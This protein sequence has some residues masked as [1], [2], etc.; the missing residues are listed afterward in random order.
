MSTAAAGDY[1]TKRMRLTVL[2]MESRP[3]TPPPPQESLVSEPEPVALS[4]AD[5]PDEPPPK[6]EQECIVDPRGDLW[7]LAQGT[8]SS[9]CSDQVRF[10]VCSRTLA[11]ASPVFDKMLFG[12]FAE[13]SQ[14]QSG[15]TWEVELP[16]D[17]SSVTRV[18]FEIMHSRYQ[19]L[20]T[21]GCEDP[22]V[23]PLLYD[24]T[25]MADKYDC[26]A[27]FRP[28]ASMWASHLDIDAHGKTELSLLRMS[29]I[30]HQLG[31]IAK[32]EAVL[33][34]LIMDYPLD[35]N[36]SEDGQRPV[37][38]VLPPDVLEDVH[39]LRLQMLRELL[40]PIARTIDKLMTS[41]DSPAGVCIF[42][43]ISRYGFSS[44][45]DELVCEALMLGLALRKLK[46]QNLWPLPEPE[47]MSIGPRALDEVITN[48][49]VACKNPTVH[50]AC[51]P[52]S[53][54]RRNRS[55]NPQ[56]TGLRWLYY[57][58]YKYE[59]GKE[60]GHFEARAFL[61]GVHEFAPDKLHKSRDILFFG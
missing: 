19:R 22:T 50:P 45:G 47:N 18:L 39:R 54:P 61:L 49:A 53:A 12:R 5:T 43:L 25:I 37:P 21:M 57:T 40:D 58:N 10:R 44:Q 42:G 2:T 16:E 33:T 24:L 15:D 4:D 13:S 35:R 23:V 9:G 59:A 29:W 56:F 46:S 38:Q 60:R 7:L 6:P 52:I 34:T 17:P 30:F 26:V 14:N 27:L 11:R 28:W 1:D 32:Y 48:L 3:S 20:K 31:H 41:N 36:I 8:D 55:D 51:S